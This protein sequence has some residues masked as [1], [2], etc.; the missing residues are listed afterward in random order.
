VSTIF[1]K[2]SHKTWHITL[3]VT[4]VFLLFLYLYHNE[5][6]D[7][8][9]PYRG[10]QIIKQSPF[11]DGYSKIYPSP[12]FND[13]AEAEHWQG[14]SV[15]QSMWYYST[16]QGSNLMPYDVFAELEQSDSSE[17][18]RSGTN[19][20]KFRYIAQ[21]A[22][23]S[24]PDGL[25]LGFVKDS[26]K[27]NEYIGLTCA[28]CHT[29]QIVYNDVA[30]RIDGGPG[31]ADFSGFM[32]N[33]KTTLQHT[34]TTPAKLSSF[35]SRVMARGNFDSAEQVEQAIKKAL[36]DITLYNAINYA[37]TEYGFARLDAFGRIYN[38]VLQY[39]L[40][41][42]QVIEVLS[43]VLTEQKVNEAMEGIH[44]GPLSG[45]QFSHLFSHIEPLLTDT[46]QEAIRAEIF[47]PADA[48]VSYPFL[49]D[50]PQHD[51]VQWNGLA[52]NAEIGPLGR[53]IGEVIGVFGTLDW[54]EKEGSSIIGRLTSAAQNGTYVEYES[55]IDVTNLR[56]M[57]S[58]ITELTSP[59]WPQAILPAIDQQQAKQG[60]KLYQQYCVSCHLPI[61]RDDPNRRVIAQ[62]DDMLKVGTDPKMAL[63]S[64]NYTGRSGIVEGSYVTTGVGSL[65]V[66]PQM[67]VA[68][69]LTAAGAN[70]VL[71][72]DPD[73]NIIHRVF[74]RAYNLIDTTMDNKVKESIKKGDHPLDTVLGPYADLKAYKARPL[75]GIWATAPY[76][77]NGSVP[78]LYDL[79]LPKKL[80]TDAEE[81][82]YRPNQFMVG[83]R[84]FDPAKVGFVTTGFNGSLFDASQLGNSNAGHE[85]AAGRTAGRDGQ[86]LPAMD[87]TQRLA[88]LEYLKTL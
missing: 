67:P 11:N 71:T 13:W 35:T 25:P 17:L 15:A 38:R 24:N 85:Y 62:I 7:D 5:R 9:D 10:A 76:L 12:D 2:I 44:T 69:I 32:K 33:L 75:N 27:D 29:G 19:M 82:E 46:Q 51:Y 73:K 28:A 61:K 87:K 36:S 48:P 68:T 55:S 78:T 16:S 47:N 52:G 14:W 50:T 23:E 26:F 30:I 42:E 40:T 66:E 20:D 1:Q 34:V 84:Q 8:T 63:N 81:G 53:N 65:Y 59:L 72:P 60:K 21:R 57:E 77:H 58:Q 74:D 18:F 70:V 3:L 4:A 56:L 80:V 31:M 39:V 41:K 83:S 6:F 45:G 37:D 43:T 22:T 79:L 88:L 49:W 86:T 54:Q 64:V